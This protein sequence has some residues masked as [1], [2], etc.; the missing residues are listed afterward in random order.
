MKT[1]LLAMLAAL[2]VAPPATA[3]DRITLGFGRI[4]TNDALG[5]GQDRWR[6]GSYQV[7]W[8]RGPDWT[9]SLPG[10][11]GQIIEYR[12]RGEIVAPSNLRDPDP[13][14]R[15]YA[16]MVSLGI[17][18]HFDWAGYET[19]LGFDLV[20]VGPSTGMGSFH[21]SM[22]ELFSMPSPAGALD[23][24]LGNAIRPTVSAEIGRSFD[25]GGTTARP[26]VEAQ[27]GVES[28]LRLGGDLTFGRFG[29][30]G[31]MLR[32]VTSGQRV[33]GIRGADGTGLTFTLGGD[34]AHVLESHLLPDGGA[35]ELRDTRSR[36]RAG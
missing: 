36:L 28:L 16:G 13:A 19:R 27:A 35:A 1:L 29:E 33:D 14:D 5:D 12:F 23:T 34:V 22:H 26:F 17:H 15:R 30:G 3:Q 7:S 6:T 32:D 31:L 8:L 24:Q 4:F 2:A 11:A 9:G 21:R 18:T 25:L 10:T 20:G